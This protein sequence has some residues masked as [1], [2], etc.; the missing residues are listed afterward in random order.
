MSRLFQQ[1][2]HKRYL[3]LLLTELAKAFP[4]KIAFKGG[5]CAYFFYNL[6]RFSFDL[7]FD[8]IRAFKA[9]D[10]DRF[11]EL[12][13]KHGQA[14]NFY[15]KANTLFCLFD[16][17][18]DYPNIKIE[19]NKRVWKNNVY[20]PVWF[21]GVPFFIADETTVLTNKLVALTDRKTAVAR[22]LFDI[23]YFLKAGFPVNGALILERTGKDA[24][25]YLTSITVFIEKTYTP[26][27]VLH[28]LG[29][30]LDEKQKVWAKGHLVLETMQEINRCI[31]NLKE[32][33]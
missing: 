6:P 20:K 10:V 19:L 2:K 3:A 33:A 28:G 24:G 4:E 22:D 30:A 14:K 31:A 9:V 1:D 13:E 17:G 27:N 25:T 12:V 15:D 5:T 16:Y 21:M 29:D 7:D 11:R 23:W 18:K 26:R 8:M 32:G